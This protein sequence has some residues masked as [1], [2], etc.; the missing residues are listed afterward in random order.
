MD[1]FDAIANRQSYRESFTADAVP[2][3]D[4]ERIVQAGLDAPS[5]CNLQ[6]TRFVIVDDPELLREIADLLPPGNARQTATALIA[7]CVSR[8][9]APSYEGHFFDVEDC[10]AAVQNMLLAITAL[11]YGTVWSDG[12]L[13]V[14]Q[15][16]E[17]IGALL[18]VP[19]ERVVRI[20]LPL[21]RP[22]TTVPRREKMAFA[23]RASFNQWAE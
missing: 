23:Q 15:R 6:T 17:R 2:C 14:E 13:R 20:I 9:P 22:A 18:G 10:A 19:E 3:A 21:G 5:G 4:L 16:A 7:C 12:V 8:E 11:G 1:L